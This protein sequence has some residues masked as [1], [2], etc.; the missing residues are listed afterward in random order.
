M[1]IGIPGQRRG[2]GRMLRSKYT[3]DGHCG[4]GRSNIGLYNQIGVFGIMEKAVF[5]KKVL[6]MITVSIDSLRNAH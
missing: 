1:F 6:I 3:G 4:Y 2:E 5:N